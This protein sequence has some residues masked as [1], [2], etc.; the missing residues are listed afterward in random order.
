MC[1]GLEF[2]VKSWWEC[3]FNKESCRYCGNILVPAI[4]CGNCDEIIVWK[5]SACKNR[6]EHIH[7]HNQNKNSE[8]AGMMPSLWT[9]NK[10]IN[11]TFIII[12]DSIKYITL[13]I[14]IFTNIQ[15][16]IRSLSLLNH[17]WILV[18]FLFFSVLYILIKIIAYE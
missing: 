17:Q 11:I 18:E 5:C 13:N 3:M 12:I 10:F 4:T 15:V 16:N 8:S 1:W 7:I 14:F 2:H 6:S 9:W